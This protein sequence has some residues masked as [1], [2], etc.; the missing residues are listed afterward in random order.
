VAAESQAGHRRPRHGVGGRVGNGPNGLVLT[1]ISS[2]PPD[3]VGDGHTD[4]DIVIPRRTVS[5]RPERSGTG[6]GRTYTIT[7]TITATAT[8]RAEPERAAVI[9]RRAAAVNGE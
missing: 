4:P 3:A 8:G 1:A 5:L 7:A 6:V 2:E 9:V